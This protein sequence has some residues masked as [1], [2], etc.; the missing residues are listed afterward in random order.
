MVL[1]LDY[2]AQIA[3]GALPYHLPYQVVTI[4]SRVV[5]AAR[6]AWADASDWAAGE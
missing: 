3:F 6:V 4:A 2:S 1:V 5:A